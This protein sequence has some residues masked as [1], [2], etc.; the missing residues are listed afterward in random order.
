MER[1]TVIEYLEVEV[2]E[3]NMNPDAKKEE[4]YMKV[5]G[6]FQPIDA[7]SKRGFSSTIVVKLEREFIHRYKDAPEDVAFLRQ[8]HRH[9]LKLEIEIE[10]SH[11]DRELEFIMVKRYVNHLFN[12]NEIDLT[13]VE[14]S[15][16]TICKELI[17]LLVKKYGERDMVITASEDGENGGRVYYFM[18]EEQE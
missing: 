12:M 17:E 15:C 9:M 5:Q 18:K 4:V 7:I 6:E 14:K 1:R 11:L 16:E 8:W 13:Y 10:V 2:M 3:E